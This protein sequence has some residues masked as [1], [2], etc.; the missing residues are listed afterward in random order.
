MEAVKRSAR[1]YT[2]EVV[3]EFPAIGKYRIRVMKK[4]DKPPSLDMREYVSSPTF[5]GFTRRGVRLAGRAEMEQLLAV[6]K[7]A[8]QVVPT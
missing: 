2:E 8:I 4:G 3:R 6:L 7:D 1:V 5:E